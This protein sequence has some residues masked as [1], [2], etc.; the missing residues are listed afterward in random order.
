MVKDA[1]SKEFLVSNFTNYK[2]VDSRHVM[3]QSMNFLEYLVS[4]HNTRLIW[5]R[6]FQSIV[7]LINSP[8]LER[9]QAYLKA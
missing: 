8:F 3:E 7:S 4:S 6:L 1:F 9:F 2:M 5:M